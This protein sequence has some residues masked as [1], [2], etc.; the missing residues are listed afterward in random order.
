MV[1]REVNKLFKDL[2]KNIIW[3]VWKEWKV[4]NLSVDIINK[5][6]FCV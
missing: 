1:Y 5:I 6:F 3:I 2:N 4:K